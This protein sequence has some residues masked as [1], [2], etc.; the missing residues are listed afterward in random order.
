MNHSLDDAAIRDVETVL[1]EAWNRHD[2]KAFASF[3]TEGADSV[4]VVGWWWRGAL[5]SRRMS[6]M[7]RYSCF[8]KASSPITK[9]MLGS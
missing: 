5:R 6:P 1:Q 4:N 2:A 3:F 7:P 9:F 8:E